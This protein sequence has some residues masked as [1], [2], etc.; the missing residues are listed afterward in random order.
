[1]V[2]TIGNGCIC[3]VRPLLSLVAPRFGESSKRDRYW[4]SPRLEYDLASFACSRDMLT[5]PGSMFFPLRLSS[6]APHW[7]FV[8][9]PRLSFDIYPGDSHRYSTNRARR[10]LVSSWDLE[11][12]WDLL[13]GRKNNPCPENDS[14]L[15]NANPRFDVVVLVRS[16]GLTKASLSVKSLG[17]KYHSS[18]LTRSLRN[19]GC[20]RCV[21]LLWIVGAIPIFWAWAE[22][23]SPHSVAP[24]Q[25]ADHLS[26]LSACMMWLEP[27]NDSSKSYAPLTC[28]TLILRDLKAEL[29]L[30]YRYGLSPKPP[31]SRTA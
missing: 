27:D 12:T 22:C 1:M 17:K 30:W 8:L 20:C 13:S 31:T 25:T 11:E 2:E 4:L 18:S 26:K 6:P 5:S 19:T 23:S 14:D 21:S 16:T 29:N 24:L 3:F 7:N 28:N 15:G 10:R 9:L